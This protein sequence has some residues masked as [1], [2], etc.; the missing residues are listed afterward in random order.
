MGTRFRNSRYTT[1]LARHLDLGN[2]PVIPND[3]GFCDVSWT[4][5]IRTSS[6]ASLSYTVNGGSWQSASMTSTPQAAGVHLEASLPPMAAESLVQFYVEATDGLGAKATY[7]AGGTNSRALYEVG[8][9]AA[10][11]PRLH[12]IRLLM[13]VADAA[14]IIRPRM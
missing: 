1:T 11:N 13:P 10:Y 12:S 9:G 5:R 8:S 2:S 7:P 3:D 14:Y 6:V 4:L